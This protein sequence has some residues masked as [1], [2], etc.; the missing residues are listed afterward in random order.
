MGSKYTLSLFDWIC[1]LN[2]RQITAANLQN[3]ILDA[4][5][6]IFNF[7]FPI[8]MEGHRIE[9]ERK[10]VMHYLRK[11]IGVETPAMWQIFLNER[12][13]LIMPY[14]NELYK[15]VD[16]EYNILEDVNWSETGSRNLDITRNAT[17]D[18]IETDIRKKSMID[19][20]TGTD[21]TTGDI[22]NNQ[23]SEV[24]GS[25]LPQANY[26]GV[27]YGTS[28]QNGT[29]NSTSK[30][31]VSLSKQSHSEGS[32]DTSDNITGKDT[33]TGNDKHTDSNTRSRKGLQ[34]NH[35]YSELIEQFRDSIV[36]IDRLIIN[37]L[38]DLFMTVY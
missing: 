31:N 23:T 9:L 21:T 30:E 37:E 27:D 13:N 38:A 29:Q 2:Q 6:K 1:M 32:E 22:T 34:G 12:L 36:N 5:P 7:D 17:V 24:L 8:Y 11:E 19:T 18:R 10:I 16:Q 33:S 28:L 35:T 20:T 26:A 4:I 3:D 14:Y 15:S 25:D